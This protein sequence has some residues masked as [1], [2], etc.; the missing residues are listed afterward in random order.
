MNMIRKY[1]YKT[2][3]RLLPI[4]AFA[5]VACTENEADPFS[6]KDNYIAAFSLTQ[7][8]TV[9]DAAIAGDVITV[10]V[11]EG[12]SLNNAKATVKLSENA[13]IYPD[14]A[15]ITAWDDEALF[16]VTAYN[17]AK[18]TYKY[19]VARSGVAREGTV[20]LETQADVDAFGQL[21]ITFID[22]NLTVGRAAGTDS[23]TSLAPLAGLKEVAYSLT[24]N[25]TYAGTG[26]EGLENLERVGGTLQVGAL[27]HL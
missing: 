1:N 25:P 13:S 18:A 19:T 24:L 9:F 14:P 4:I 21:G 12:L 27:K 3:L 15:K 17:G 7:G 8:N 2:V 20:V 10:T 6:G 22:G 11:P 5:F 23:I 26:L 16:A